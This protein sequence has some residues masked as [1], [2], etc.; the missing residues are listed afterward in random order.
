MDVSFETIIQKKIIN[1]KKII[2]SSI[3]SNQVN[4][5]LDFIESNDLNLC[6]EYAEGIYDSLTDLSN[7]INTITQDEVIDNL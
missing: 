6:I 5:N 3:K 2:K 4:K 7:C 1:L